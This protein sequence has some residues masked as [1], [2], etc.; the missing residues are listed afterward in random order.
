MHWLVMWLVDDPRI[1]QNS[2][3]YKGEAARYEGQ[4]SP[5]QAKP[6][7]AKPSQAKP[8][9]TRPGQAKPSQNKPILVVSFIGF[10]SH[11]GGYTIP[12]D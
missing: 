5:G 4:A 3:R 1:L 12:D 7:Q 8:G 11:G 2:K 9:R 10:A 6:S